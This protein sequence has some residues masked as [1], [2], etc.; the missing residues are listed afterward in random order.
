MVRWQLQA[1]R[2]H[3]PESPRWN[4]TLTPQIFLLKSRF[5]VERVLTYYCF[6]TV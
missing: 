4:G 1:H 6:L 2:G 5:D 3:G